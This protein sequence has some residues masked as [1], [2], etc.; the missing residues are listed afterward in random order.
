VLLIGLLLGGKTLVAYLLAR[1]ARLPRPLQVSVGLS[2]V[3]EFSFVL[4]TLLL[5]SGRIPEEL[6]AALLAV[7]ILS[8]AFSAVAA[9]LPVAGWRPEVDPAAA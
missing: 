2:Q 5:A 6:H 1:A 7:V 8:I 3:G 9:R 4:G